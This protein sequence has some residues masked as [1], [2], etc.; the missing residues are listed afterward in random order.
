MEMGCSFTQHRRMSQI[1]EQGA[2][3][4]T[5]SG[6]AWEEETLGRGEGWNEW[7]EGRGSPGDSVPAGGLGASHTVSGN[8]ALS[9]PLPAVCV[10]PLCNVHL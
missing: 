10:Y 6:L 1:T 3:V 5:A 8:G 4:L 2:S 7:L 9:A